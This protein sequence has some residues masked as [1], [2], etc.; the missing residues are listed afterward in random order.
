MRQIIGGK[1]FYEDSKGRMVPEELVKDY[2]QL[3]DQV[4]MDSFAGLKDLREHM[5]EVKAKIMDDLYALIQVF[6]DQYGVKLGGSKGNVTVSS[7]DGKV[8]LVIATNEY[9]SFN[10]NLHLA[11]KVI[12]QCIEKWS[13]GANVNL[14]TVIDQAFA[15][16]KAGRFNVASVM[17]LRRLAIDDPDWIKAMAIIS[18]SI[19]TS[20]SRKYFRVY[21]RT[22]ADDPYSMVQ[23]DLADL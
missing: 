15:L 4:V 8:K 3:K 16:N 1:V 5:I 7:F 9:Q 13:E 6:A 14:K 11:K 17:G 19:E 12:D 10:E 22:N 23:F 18:D 20:C 2:D 21:T